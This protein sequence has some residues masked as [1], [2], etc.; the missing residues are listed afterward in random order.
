VNLVAKLNQFYDEQ[1]H[2]NEDPFVAETARAMVQSYLARWEREDAKT[3]V[4]GIEVPFKVALPVPSD[5]P[6]WAMPAKTRFVGGIIDSIIERDGRVLLTDLKTTSRLTPAY[7]DE[8]YTNPQL[9]QYCFGLYCAGYEK[10][11]CEWD[12]ILKL[13]TKPK[14]LTKKVIAE[15]DSGMFYDWPV[16]V[17]IPADKQETPYLWGLRLWSSYLEKPGN[18]ERRTYDRDAKELLDFV[19]ASHALQSEIERSQGLGGDLGL[20]YRKNHHACKSFNTTCEFHAICSGRD[21]EKLGYK[22]REKSVEG[23]DLGVTPSQAGTW[24]LC[25]AKWQFRY[26]ERIEPK[27]NQGTQATALG[28]LVHEGRSIILQDRL[29]DPIVMPMEGDQ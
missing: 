11:S 16:D 2:K 3:K 22:S 13:D 26:G 7:F 14:Q 9:T 21:P 1:A 8:L 6:S 29:D 5:L 4:R 19:Y 24:N 15:L 17:E 25:H 28:S 23:R 27:V 10:V 12:V 18:F 20:V